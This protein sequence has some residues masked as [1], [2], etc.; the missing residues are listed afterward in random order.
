MHYRYLLLLYLILTAGCLSPKTSNFIGEEAPII[1]DTF[2]ATRAPGWSTLFNRTSGWLGADGIYSIPCTTRMADNEPCT[3]F[4]FSD[5]VLGEVNDGIIQPGA[6]MVH[7]SVARLIGEHPEEKNIDFYWATDEKGVP[8][9][10]FVPQTPDT[11]PGDWYWL[12]D[13]FVNRARDNTLY[14][15]AYQLRKNEDGPPGFNF[16]IVDVALIAIPSH[17][18]P[19]FEAHS[20]LETPLYRPAKDGQEKMLFGAGILV[21]TTAAGTPDP[22]G[23]VY[24]YGLKEHPGERKLV[25]ARVRPGAFETFTAWRF[26]NGTE[27]V[28]N[29]AEAAPLASNVSPEL[30]VSPLEDGRYV[31][32]YQLKTLSPQV[33]VRFGESPV[34]PFGPPQTIWRCP[35]AVQDSIYCYNAKAHPHLSDPGELLI[36]YNVNTFTFWDIFKY[37]GLYRPRFIRVRTHDLTSQ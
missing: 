10:L 26:W 18:R 31:L 35:E 23:Y 11:E 32:T 2:A 7:N 28:R 8:D 25:A 33:V 21:N 17:S 14:L 29:M 36:S 4:F 15:F 5:T 22:D 37:A 6:K 19:P 12:G 3:L 34:G 30:S 13:G 9:A 27:W 16:K 24:V 1:P 20:Q